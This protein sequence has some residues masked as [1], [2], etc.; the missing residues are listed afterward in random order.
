MLSKPRNSS[1]NKLR[2]IYTSP[3]K[4]AGPG[5]P[6]QDMTLGEP[7][8]YYMDVYEGGRE[9]EK[10]WRAASNSLVSTMVA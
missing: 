2:N 7:P 4:A 5:R 8:K 6:W 10:V 1:A 9:K 3:A